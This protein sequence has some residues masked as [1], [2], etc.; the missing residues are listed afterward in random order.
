MIDKRYDLDTHYP[1]GLSKIELILYS[2]F[3][4][5]EIGRLVNE[6]FI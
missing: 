5:F 3:V 4:D 6:T 2:W 1:T